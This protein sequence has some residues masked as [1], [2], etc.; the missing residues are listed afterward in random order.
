VNLTQLETIVWISRLGSFRAASEKMNSAQPTISMR[1]RELETELGFKIFDRTHRTVELTPRGRICI[2]FAKRILATAA[3]FKATVESDAGL[4]GRVAVGVVEDIALTWLPTLLERVTA[5]YP[6]LSV[7]LHIDLTLPLMRKLD[8][9]EI[10]VA[11]IGGGLP[12]AGLAVRPLGYVH[13]VWMCK[14]GSVSTVKPLA[15]KEL[16]TMP[17]LTWSEEAALHEIVNHWFVSNG[18]YPTKI[19]LSNSMTSLASL[20]K[21]GL[22]ISLLPLE[23]YEVDVKRGLLSVISTSPPFDPAP[24]SAVYKSTMWPPF[25]QTIAVLAEEVST[26]HPREKPRNRARR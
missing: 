14:A 13:Y 21:A 17:I 11:L 1:V 6:G 26:F 24:Y 15:P 9:G 8:R 18:A 20:T 23:L 3:D 10:D 25:S 12:T 22:G 4:T 2:D 19:N 5:T 7:D 16:Q